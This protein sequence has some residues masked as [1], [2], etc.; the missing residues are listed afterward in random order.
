MD[1]CNPAAV[2][3]FHAGLASVRAAGVDGF[4]FDGGDPAFYT[5]ARSSLDDD[6]EPRAGRTAAAPGAT[7]LPHAQCE[8]FARFGLRYDIAEF[9]ASWK[10][11]RATP[12]CMLA[13]LRACMRELLVCLSVCVREKGR[14]LLL[15]CRERGGLC[16]GVACGADARAATHASLAAPPALRLRPCIALPRV[17]HLSSCH[18]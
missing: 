16:C 3:W 13:Y 5:G 12:A 6:G 15:Q 9:R 14:Q 2:A 1:F 7:S 10:V 11:R 18:C 4:K 8:A 17:P